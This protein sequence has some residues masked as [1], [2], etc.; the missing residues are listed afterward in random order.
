MKS[1]EKLQRI[2]NKDFCLMVS[3]PLPTKSVTCFK[4][5]KSLMPVSEDGNIVT[6]R[7]EATDVCL[8]DNPDLRD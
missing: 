3:S 1:V 2:F 8:L 5:K 6:G 4:R 7:T